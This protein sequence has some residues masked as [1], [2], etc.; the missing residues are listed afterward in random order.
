MYCEEEQN[1]QLYHFIV[2]EKFEFH[3]NEVDDYYNEDS[4]SDNQQ[5]TT[6]DQESWL[7]FYLD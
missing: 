4:D 6:N 2:Y 5:M 7:T 3:I 1:C